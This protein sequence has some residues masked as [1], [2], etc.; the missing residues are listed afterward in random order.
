M[1]EVRQLLCPHVFMEDIQKR[2]KLILSQMRK[3]IHQSQVVEQV[4]L[5]FIMKCEECGNSDENNT[6]YDELTGTRI[7]LGLDCMGCG[8]VLREQ[9]MQAPFVSSSDEENIYELYSPQNS[10]VVETTRNNHFKR[11]TQTIEKNLSRY[12]RED[13][14]TSDA[15]KDDQRRQVYYLLDHVEFHTSLDSDVINK[16]KMLFHEYRTKMYRIHKLETAVCCLIYI[17]INEL[18]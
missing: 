1:E 5:Q 10:F 14:V 9:C 13:T 17:V 3:P 15:Y 6:I 12:G 4:P 16:V 18:H 2:S 7:C 11:M 8:V